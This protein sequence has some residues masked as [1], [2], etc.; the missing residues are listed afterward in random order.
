MKQIIRNCRE[1]DIP[2]LFNIFKSAYRFN[3][4]LQKR[5]YFDWQYK[6]TPFSKMDKYTFLVLE[7]NSVIKGFLGYL[8]VRFRY[9]SEILDGCWMYNWYSLEKGISGLRLLTRLM[10]DYDNRFLINM[11]PVALDIYSW[12]QIPLIKKIPRWLGILDSARAISLFAESSTDSTLLGKS[13]ERLRMCD[14]IGDIHTCDRFQEDEEFLF[15]AWPSVK[16]HCLRTGRYLNWR[17]KEIPD[18]NYRMIRDSEGHYA[19]YRIEPVIHYEEKV[20]RLLEWNFS[21][22]QTKN[23]LSVIVQD[24][25]QN[26]SILIDFFCTAVEIGNELT[27]LGFFPEEALEKRIPYLFKP[28]NYKEGIPVGVDLSS[29]GKKQIFNFN[30]WYIT[31]GD[32]DSERI[33]S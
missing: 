19:V 31:F 24:S 21:G 33:K 3:L 26:G 14:D 13:A 27:G 12:Y 29:S 7:E 11:T 20:T 4:C 17:Y 28:I 25:M 16:G 18:H 6:N 1:A 15:D 9:G 30:E 32:S 22:K 10:T 5:K 23:A 8:P 2:Q